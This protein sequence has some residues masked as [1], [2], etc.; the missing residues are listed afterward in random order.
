MSE[1]AI[2][3]DPLWDAV[4]SS[5]NLEGVSWSYDM[6]SV[7]NLL[8][9]AWPSSRIQNQFFEAIVRNNVTSSPMW[10]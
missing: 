9:L 10:S 6:E 4:S 8:R 5:V 1:A 7:E 2:D 3:F